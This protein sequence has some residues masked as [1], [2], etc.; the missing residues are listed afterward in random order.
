ML[1]AVVLV[2]A[3]GCGGERGG[4]KAADEETAK[5]GKTDAGA[6]LLAASDVGAATRADLVAGVPVSGTLAPWVDVRI[7]APVVEVID[8]VLV[9]EGQSVAKGQLLARFRM[10]AIEAAATG[11]KAQLKVATA[12]YERFK[13]L[14]SEGAISQREVDAAEAAWR[15]AKANEAQAVRH[16]EDANVRAPVAG[17]ISVKSVA[18]GDRPGEGDPMFRLVNT[19]ELDFEA[20]VPS[21]FVPQV[22]VGSSVRLSISG[23]PAGSI[24]GRVARINAAVDEATRQVKVYVQVPNKGG[25]LVGGLFATGNVVTKE[26]R[27]VVAVPSRGV[28]TEGDQ[29]FALVIKNGKIERRDVTVGLRDEALDLVEIAAG[30]APGDVVVTGPTE[31]LTPGRTVQVTGKES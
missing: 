18:A 30:L 16:W 14:L 25:R 23:F 4:A 13:N 28:R 26:A 20:T 15:V 22:K 7:S 3:A 12:D 8:E 21:E 24:S 17:V 11:A 27:G 31:G 2:V 19:S 9:R 29:S 5:K 10:G 1:L 6:A